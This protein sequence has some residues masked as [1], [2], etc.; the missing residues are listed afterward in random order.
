MSTLF[1]GGINIRHCQV[2]S[3]S[4]V[5]QW[6]G[7]TYLWTRFTIRVRGVY[8][9]AFNAYELDGGVPVSIAPVPSIPFT[10]RGSGPETDYATKHI[11]MQPR[12]QLAYAVDDV[13][14]ILFSPAQGYT[15]DANNGPLPVSC[16]IIKIGGQKSVIVDYTVMT[17]INE[18]GL[19][20]NGSIPS[21]LLSHRWTMSERIDQ[22]FFSTRTINGH[23]IFRSDRMQAIGADPDD[24]RAYLAHYVPPNFKRDDISIEVSEDGQELHYVLVD[25]EKAFNLDPSLL[26]LNVTRIEGT[27]TKGFTKQSAFDAKVALVRPIPTTIGG[28][29]G[30][31]FD[32]IGTIRDY[33]ITAENTVPR[34][35]Q[36]LHVRVYGN[37][38]AV[39]GDLANVATAVLLAKISP[40]EIALGSCTAMLTEDLLGEFVELSVNIQSGPESQVAFQ[41]QG[42]AP[43]FHIGTETINGI[44]TIE[45][46]PQP[47]PPSDSGSRGTNVKKLQSQTVEG[48]CGI[49]DI[50]P[51]PVNY[52]DRSPP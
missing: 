40:L 16:D 9:P 19:T 5:A 21:A 33:Y 32:P 46:T 37:R 49:P 44:T 27:Y 6:D 11:L 3:Y 35:I 38:F 13:N 47:F 50:G 41:A 12:G 48:P 15:T 8:N 20:T 1:Y 7:P 31:F 45:E 28:W 26:A 24:Y 18:C 43:L 2:L 23:A 22:D 17:D 51:V 42:L 25:R 52:Q 39:R 10:V 4:R 14:P 30:T 36:S 34:I 29:V